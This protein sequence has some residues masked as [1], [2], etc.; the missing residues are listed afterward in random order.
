M[1][2]RQQRQRDPAKR[3]GDAERDAKRPAD[4]NRKRDANRHTCQHDFPYAAACVYCHREAITSGA[5]YPCPVCNEF[6]DFLAFFSDRWGRHRSVAYHKPSP[7]RDGW[8]CT[9]PDET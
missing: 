4:S 1:D 2:D 8:T 6:A 7:D 9:S 5:R 3:H